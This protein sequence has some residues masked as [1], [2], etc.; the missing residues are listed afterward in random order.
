MID[1]AKLY[2]ETRR[3]KISKLGLACLSA[4]KNYGGLTITPTA[5]KKMIG[6]PCTL[7]SVSQQ[8]AN[9]RDY[10]LIET[11][12]SIVNKREF[13]IHLTR[14]GDAFITEFMTDL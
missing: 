3:R 2:A 11:H 9:L 4:L 7:S 8:L 5:L 12:P 6:T 1:W 10:E 13:R 14:K